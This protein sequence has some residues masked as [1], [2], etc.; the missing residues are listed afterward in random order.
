MEKYTKEEY[1]DKLSK[2]L[3]DNNMSIGEYYHNL[4]ID[5][6][7]DKEISE[8][9]K[10]NPIINIDVIKNNLNTHKDNM[11]NTIV[12][13]ILLNVSNKIK[14]DE[15]NKQVNEYIS[16]LKN[17]STI[18][19][20]SLDEIVTTKRVSE[21]KEE[22]SKT[23]IDN[24]VNRKPKKIV[25]VNIVEAMN[26]MINDPDKDN[27][28]FEKDN[29]SL[30]FY[31]FMDYVLEKCSEKDS[32]HIGHE[33]DN[34]INSYKELES[35]YNETS[36][37]GLKKGIYVNQARLVKYITTLDLKKINNTNKVKEK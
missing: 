7:K 10:K 15:E 32:F 9:E 1:F 23:I 37:E 12:A 29:I 31:T 28:Y 16:M 26:N 11:I 8:L 27:Y 3:S 24:K 13:T 34:K 20:L 33:Y 25:C 2:Y 6:K 30:D 4:V 22:Y 35:M 17:E 18:N 19:N 5:I 14:N 36:R 21:E